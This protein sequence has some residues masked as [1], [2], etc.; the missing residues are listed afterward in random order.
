[1]PPDA[2]PRLNAA[3]EGRY[4]IE[5]E[6]GEG[7]MATVYLAQDLRDERRVEPGKLQRPPRLMLVT[8]LVGELRALDDG[9]R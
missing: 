2:I 3:L 9:G 6:V 7:G 4:V 5:R 8:D 1:M